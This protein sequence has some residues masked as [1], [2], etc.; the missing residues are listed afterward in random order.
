MIDRIRQFL[1][2]RQ[3]A[4]HQCFGSP[5]GNEVLVDLAKFCRAAETCYHDDPRKHAVLEGR[6]EVFIRIADH[7]NLTVDQIYALYAGRN[8]LTQKENE[9]A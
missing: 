7:M 9:N 4:Y 5:A 3:R 2:H 8:V 6:R 1:Q